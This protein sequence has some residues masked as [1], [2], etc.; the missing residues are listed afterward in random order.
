LK[1]YATGSNGTINFLSNVT[2]SSPT[3]IL[4]AH[5]I[6]ISQGVVVMI[7]SPQQASVFT[8]NPHYFGFG[9]TGSPVNQWHFRRRWRKGSASIGCC[10]A[11]G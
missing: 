6:N 10:T 9:G 3:N 2:L 11:A 4:A 5:T 8:D 7:N 1:L